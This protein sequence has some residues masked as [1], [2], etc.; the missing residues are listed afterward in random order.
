MLHYSNGPCIVGFPT[1][2]DGWKYFNEK[3]YNYSSEKNAWIN[4]SN[5]CQKGDANLV[6]IN[7]EEEQVNLCFSLYKT[8]DDVE[9]FLHL[10]YSFTT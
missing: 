10:S 6:V 4:S 1:C 9:L 2:P 7:H 5:L 8:I 3:C